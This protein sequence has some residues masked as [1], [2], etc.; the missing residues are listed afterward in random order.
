MTKKI[1][2]SLI[3]LIGCVTYS[4]LAQSSQ[5][6]MRVSVRVVSGTSVETIQPDVAMLYESSDTDLGNMDLKGIDSQNVIIS[7]SEEVL[8]RDS[9]GN[10][11]NLDISTQKSY[12]ED[13]SASIRLIGSSKERMKSGSYNGKLTTTIQYM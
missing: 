13:Q 7:I 4:A 9:N 12:K 2:I 1:I 6:T 3:V 5:S 11:I 8:L 10:E